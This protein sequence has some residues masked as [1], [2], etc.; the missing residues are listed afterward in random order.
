MACEITIISARK[1]GLTHEECIEYLEREHAP[2]VKELLGLKR[3]VTSVPL[4]S[5]RLD[6]PLD[7]TGTSYDVVVQ[8]QF[9]SLSDL[10]A[11]FDSA[12][13]RRVRQDAGNF[14]DV[15]EN[16]VFATIDET[17]RYQAIPEGFCI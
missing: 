16:V 12:D 10:R 7:P 17:L 13:G 11:A 4:N 5:D 6:C 8:L 14:V 1:E 15:A 9:E 2:L 3:F